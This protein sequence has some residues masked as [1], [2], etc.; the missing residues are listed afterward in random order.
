[1][2]TLR[3]AASARL[4]I[5]ESSRLASSAFAS[6]PSAGSLSVGTSIGPASFQLVREHRHGGMFTVLKVRSRPD[7]EDGTGW[8][9]HPKGTVAAPASRERMSADGID[10]ERE[11]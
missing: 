9:Q 8:Y 11:S 2:P 1:M 7:Q 3:L 10:P 5:S 4:T 6:K